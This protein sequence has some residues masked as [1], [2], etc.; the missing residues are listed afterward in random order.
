M[1]RGRRLHKKLNSLVSGSGSEGLSVPF[2]SRL[3]SDS[4]SL[5]PD[6]EIH[7]ELGLATLYEPS[8]PTGAAADIVFVHGLGGGSRKTWSY[9]PARHHYWPQAWLSNDPDFA[10]VRIHSFGYKSDWAERQSSILNIHDFAESLVGELKNH[11]SIR[12]SN[13]RIIFV[14]HSMGGC[15]AK[16]AYILARQDP[17]CKDLAGRVH[18]MFFLG[19]PHRGSD[20]AAIL[21]RLS[22]IAWGSKPFVADLIPHSS[23]L[24]EI[25]D[26]FRHYASGLRLWSFYETLP[27]KPR[28][29]NKIVVEKQSAT[30]GYPDEEIVSMNADHR[31]LCKFDSQD[32]PN[33]KILR[34]A[35]H[36]A[37]DVLRS[38]PPWNLAPSQLHGDS[39][40]ARQDLSNESVRKR[41]RSLLGILSYPEDNLEMLK[42]CQ[43]PGSCRWFSESE[44]FVSWR[45]D[46][47][48]GILWLTGRP[49]SG[50]SVLASHVIEQVTSSGALCSYFFFTQRE[51][52]KSTLNDCMRSL[53]FQMS[54]QD[55][56]VADKLL[57]IL[58]EGMTWD[59]IDELSV[60]RRLF[61]NGVFKSPSVSQHH[62][63]IDGVDECTNFKALFAKRIVATLPTGLR[64]FATSRH[65]DEI[66]RGLASLGSRVSL[67]SL[68]DTDT[69][70]DMRR[71][72][73]SRLK[74]LGRLEND[75]S[76]AMMC[77]KIL[78][79]SS[80]SFLWVRL[81]L[82]EFEDV[83]TLEAMDAILTEV[84]I[85][86][87][88][89]YRRM[90]Q[91]IEN[92]KRGSR[93]ARSI[94]MWSALA[95]RPLTTE[96]LLV[97][98][99]LDGHETPQNMRK[100][101]P[102]LCHQLV[103]VDKTDRVHI[104]HATVR[105]FLLDENLYS[106]FPTYS[107]IEHGYIGSLLLRYLV[108]NIS[109]LDIPPK[110]RSTGLRSFEK[111]ACTSSSELYLLDYA[112]RFFSEHIYQA[113]QREGVLM[114]ELCT[115]LNGKA[116]LS[117]IER[118]ARLGNVGDIIRTA[119]NLRGYLD[120]RNK[121]QLPVNPSVYLI[122]DWVIDLIRVT[123]RFG[124][125]LLA[126]PSSIHYII[127][128]ICPSE[129]IISKTFAK[130]TRTLTIDVVGIRSDIWD[131]CWARIDFAE[132]RPI[133]S[134]SGTRFLAIA[135]TT[136]HIE[137]YD[138][139]S[140]QRLTDF[141]HDGTAYMVGFSD[142]GEYL[143]SF[144]RRTVAIWQLK[145]GERRFWFPLPSRTIAFAFLGGNQLLCAF[146]SG[147]LTKWNLD[148]GEHE[149]ACW[150]DV[151]DENKYGASV[152]PE[153]PPSCAAFS[154]TGSM[155]ML[156]VGYRKHPIFIWNALELQLLGQ[157]DAV[158]NNGLDDMTFNPNP[159]ITALIVSYNDGRLCLFDYTTTL[160]AF[161]RPDV[162]AMSIACSPDG[163]SLVTG[164]NRGMLE[165]FRFEHDHLGNMVLVPIYRVQAFD[166]NI[167][168]VAFG[169]DGRRVIELHYQQCCIWVP[170]ALI[171]K[172]KN[173]SDIV[174]TFSMVGTDDSE[175]S[176]ITTAPVVSSNGCCVI[177][178]KSNGDV[179]VFSAVDGGE[180][181][182]LYKHGC[183]VEVVR[184]AIGEARNLVVSADD[185]GRVLV[186]QLTMSLPD[187]SAAR[188][189]PA[190]H[191][192]QDRRLR[193]SVHNLLL[194]PSNYRLLI[195]GNFA[196]SLWDLS[197]SRMLGSIPHH[198]TY[199]P[200]FFQHPTNDAW[201]VGLDYYT[202]SMFY[203]SDCQELTSA[204]GITSY[205]VVNETFLT[206][207]SSCYVRQ[208]FVIEFLDRGLAEAPRIYVWPT[209]A[210]DQ[211]TL[212]G[213]REQLATEVDLDAI[214]TDIL[215]VLG[216]LGQSTIL[217]VDVNLW[218]YS[219]E[220]PLTQ[221]P[222]HVYASF[223]PEPTGQKLS[224]VC[225][226]RHFFG[227]SEWRTTGARLRC[228]V[229][230]R[231]GRTDFVISS[232][233][234]III[235][236]HGLESWEDMTI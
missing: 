132:A 183:G 70:A 59:T 151:H 117:W 91:L 5:V 142:D 230:Q 78:A 36:T 137:L 126:C 1:G 114:D 194:D 217:L 193:T 162:F 93:L 186:A 196:S 127:P 212:P 199:Y 138:Q 184:V 105:E 122:N 42:L 124:S 26:T 200:A 197:S 75:E 141:H 145:S 7:G 203:W 28:W 185:S 116:I 88:D 92:N 113:T 48:P 66:E 221:I 103:F 95:C 46:A 208:D 33:Y 152:I 216:I 224:P 191:I 104:L 226:R 52:N 84:P 47:S 157:C 87:Q 195:T 144:D 153:H 218:V 74:E 215:A 120:R 31:E 82:Q 16:K 204:N 79:K 62:W 109:K 174:P 228:A 236:K 136:G 148:S 187:C 23:M 61:I 19:T 60:W 167:Y 225:V 140:A 57:Q 9:S 133:S 68:S 198:T 192:I 90:L 64:L 32:D 107:I 40:S 165:I 108:S 111:P 10:D 110:R 143:A 73:T 181:G 182:V 170:A 210:F 96:E 3:I 190:A 234:H 29:L 232:R 222:L 166:D 27:V 123:A 220:L 55:I 160:L 11:P 175:L 163:N 214:G 63:I 176:E 65:L 188:V 15:V 86:L 102:S 81:V 112:A 53:A 229:A 34:N 155:A 44:H 179:S 6:D 173:V 115:F 101:T 168:K 56:Q 201:F 205:A 178:G 125:Q 30:L 39:T 150:R 38:L 121:G 100:A 85:D 119:T 161:T 128:S 22:V 233:R 2:N 21:Q 94:L 146:E 139:H 231:N 219:M 135:L 209:S 213:H 50:K 49:G 223:L 43:Q 24:T 97:A 13:T 134:S 17:T 129:S 20:L 189:L 69:L 149:T 156:A 67:Q 4:V 72:A 58:D 172:Q 158:E 25:N 51:A 211:A 98:V 130:E 154:T 35:L 202:A 131:D 83:W 180:L 227:L 207:R 18:S 12:R 41:L 71:F 8:C 159:E 76:I 164:S 235:V 89:M 169:A 80:G 118:V 37:V 171:R 45:G 14:C 147:E 206:G 99:K 54:M 77:E 106:E 177:V